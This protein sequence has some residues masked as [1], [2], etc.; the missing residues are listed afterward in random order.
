MMIA[1]VTDQFRF[2]F[3]GL[4]ADQTRLG[5]DLRDARIIQ[6]VCTS[7]LI[8]CLM[9]DAQCLK[10][11][12]TK[13]GSVLQRRVVLAEVLLQP[14]PCGKYLVAFGAFERVLDLRGIDRR[15]FTHVCQ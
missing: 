12:S 5:E 7:S 13:F 11:I 3:E 9:N 10:L 15:L 4:L 1:K 14:L 6:E 2:A 8:H